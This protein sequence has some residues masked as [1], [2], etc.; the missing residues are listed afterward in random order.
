M[1]DLKPKCDNCDST[2]TEL[3]KTKIAVF[4]LLND[5]NIEKKIVEQRLKSGLRN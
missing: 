3:R 4:N 1:S 5:L 2:E